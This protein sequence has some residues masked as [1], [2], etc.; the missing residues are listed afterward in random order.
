VLTGLGRRIDKSISGVS[1]NTSA[2]IDTAIA[3]LMG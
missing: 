3:G 1:V 2:D